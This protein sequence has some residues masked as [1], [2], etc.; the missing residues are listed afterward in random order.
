MNTLHPYQDHNRL[1]WMKF[2]LLEHTANLAAMK[3]QDI[4]IQPKSEM[5]PEEINGVLTEARIKGKSIEIQTS[6]IVDDSFPPDIVGYIN[7]YNELDLYVRHDF[8]AYESISNVDFYEDI[9][10]FDVK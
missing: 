1:Q 5:T 10:W 7:G 4:P 6:E 3:Q 9:K 8:V 2:Y